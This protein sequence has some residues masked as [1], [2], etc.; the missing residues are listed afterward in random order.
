MS[1]I[2]IGA[3]SEATHTSPNNTESVSPQLGELV[4]AVRLSK[5]LTLAEIADEKISAAALSKFENGKAD[6]TLTKFVHLLE[7]LWITPEEMIY[8]YFENMPTETFNFNGYPSL[9]N[10]LT[11]WMPFD[12]GVT[13]SDQPEDQAQTDQAF[14]QYISLARQRAEQSTD[15]IV[16]LALDFWQMMQQFTIDLTQGHFG[17]PQP[18][19]VN[20]VLRYLNQLDDWTEFDLFLFTGFSIGMTDQQSLA[21]FKLVLSRGQ[22]YFHFRSEQDLLFRLIE[23][24]FNLMMGHQNYELAEYYLSTFHENLEKANN[25]SNHITYLFDRG[26]FNLR[27]G[28]PI[29]GE[30]DC[31]QVLTVARFLDLSDL[32]AD[33]KWRLHFFQTHPSNQD[34]K[35]VQIYLN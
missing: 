31:Q 28:N 10:L 9:G 33:F 8:R 24:Q 16:Q 18:Q 7:R 27:A 29:D 13:F 30:R 15:R 26:W 11:R 23:N 12:R 1:K 32:E 5:G 3:A 20:P 2:Q 25:A 6:L 14:Q 34:W 35:T 21:L 19:Y 22:K 4:R 17:L